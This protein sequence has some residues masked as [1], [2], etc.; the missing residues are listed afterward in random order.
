LVLSRRQNEAIVLPGLNITIRVAV[1]KG[2]AVRLG[3]DAPP[4]VAIL[5][6]EL[7]SPPHSRPEPPEPCLVVGR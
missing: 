7:L 3:I 6:E 5:R 2:N 4:D 1:I